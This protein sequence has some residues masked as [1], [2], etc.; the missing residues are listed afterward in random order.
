MTTE[1]NLT[2][3]A[4]LEKEKKEKQNK[5]KELQKILLDLQTQ[6]AKLKGKPLPVGEIPWYQRYWKYLAVGGIGTVIAGIA[7]AKKKK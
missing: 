4:Q 5:V 2:K 7:I 1:E 3:L 6:L